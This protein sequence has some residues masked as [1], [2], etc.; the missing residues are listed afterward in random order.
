M[1]PGPKGSPLNH[2]CA[3]C[4]DG[5]LMKPQQ[6]HQKGP[7]GQ[8]T[9][10]TEDLPPWPQPSGIFEEGTTFH[11]TVFLRAVA[12]L[13]SH[14]VTHNSTGGAYTME[15]LAFTEMLPSHK[16]TIVIPTSNTAPAA[17]AGLSGE[18]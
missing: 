9:T 10:V 11:P 1:W 8:I 15:Y 4:S 17:G 5:V 2:K 14:M 6:V 7:D 18:S 13:Y 12:Q 16:Q 3:F